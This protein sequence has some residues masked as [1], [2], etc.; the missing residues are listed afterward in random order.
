M[1]LEQDIENIV[2]SYGARVYDIETTKEFDDTIYRVY[3]L[4]DGGVSLDLCVDI[5]RDISPLLDVEAPVSGDYRFEVSSP[6][7]ERKL[8]KPRHFINSVGEKVKVKVL[9]GTKLKGTLKSADENGIEV[10][11]KD[12]IS[13]FKYSELGTVKTY[14]EW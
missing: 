6:G 11:S 13:S 2:K 14:F 10:E 4:K 3:I 7:I 9:G 1:A 12:G 8:T 5:S